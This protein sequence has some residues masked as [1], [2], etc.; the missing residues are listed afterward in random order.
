MGSEM[1]IR[2]RPEGEPLVRPVTAEE[3]VTLPADARAIPGADW[4]VVDKDF[5]WTFAQPH[6]AD[7]GPYF[8]R[9][10]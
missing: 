7:R 6:E 9:K 5:T 4:Y 2:D 10:A 1:C 8:C 3:L